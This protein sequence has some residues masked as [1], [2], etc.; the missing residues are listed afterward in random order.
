MLA[1][2]NETLS[3][4]GLLLRSTFVCPRDRHAGSGRSIRT[5]GRRVV[6]YIL[7]L[8]ELSASS[9]A[10][11]AAIIGLAGLLIG[12]VTDAIMGDRGFGVVG[13]ALLTI[14]GCVI[15]VYAEFVFLGP[16]YVQDLLMTA[17]AAATGAAAMLLTFGVIKHWVQD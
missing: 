7:R 10:F 11:L 4:R 9:L 1:G 16:A 12:T 14:M 3:P 6:F 17:L 8:D 15:G 13:N 2:R 5:P